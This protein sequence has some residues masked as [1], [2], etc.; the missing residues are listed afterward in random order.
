[1]PK[2]RFQTL[3]RQVLHEP[4]LAGPLPFWPADNPWLKTIAGGRPAL[5]RNHIWPEVIRIADSG[6]SEHCQYQACMHI[7][8]RGLDEQ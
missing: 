4:I 8:A 3:T 2:P 6:M 1:M 7:H 5:R